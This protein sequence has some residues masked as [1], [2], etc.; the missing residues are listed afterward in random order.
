MAAHHDCVLVD[1]QALF[2]TIGQHGLLDDHLFQDNVHPSLLGHVALAQGILDALHKRGAWGWT[3]EA[4]ATRIDIAQCAAHF[5]L[6]P[7]DWRN[8]ADRAFGFQHAAT[9]F[10]YD[11]A[12]RWA[13]MRVWI[14]ATKR[15]AVGELPESIGLSNLGIPP[16][17][18][19][20]TEGPVG[21]ALD[22]RD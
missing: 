12:Q 9:S 3:G 19:D 18:R 6:Q 17:L 1:G 16:R 8:I 4:P 22:R 5:G 10:C 2:H 15:L 21:Q 13:K 14:E 7:A 20:S 11:P